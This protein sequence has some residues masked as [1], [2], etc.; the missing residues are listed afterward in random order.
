VA[1]LAELVVRHKVY[2]TH[3]LVCSR[4]PSSRRG[5]LGLLAISYMI[6]N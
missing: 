2:W 6:F 4:F 3:L 5:F 1:S